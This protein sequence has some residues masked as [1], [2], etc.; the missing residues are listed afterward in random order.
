MSDAQIHVRADRSCMTTSDVCAGRPLGLVPS[1]VLDYNVA[2]I[3]AAEDGVPGPRVRA[4]RA[5]PR[6]IWALGLVSMFMDLSSEMIH[7]LLPVFLVSVLGATALS[8]GVIEGVA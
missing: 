7:S 6:S 1:A 2:V 4:L 3:P 8:V 5:I